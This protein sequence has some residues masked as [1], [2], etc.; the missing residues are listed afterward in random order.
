MSPP[1]S[2]PIM[3]RTAVA[4]HPMACRPGKI[5]RAMRPMIKPKIRNPMMLMCSPEMVHQGML[6]FE[7]AHACLVAWTEEAGAPGPHRT[8]TA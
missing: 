3:P 1:T 8:R 2:E 4:N 5:A 6:H 7:G